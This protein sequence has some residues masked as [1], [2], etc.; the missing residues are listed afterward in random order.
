MASAAPKGGLGGWRGGCGRPIHFPRNTSLP[1]FARPPLLGYRSFDRIYSA[2]PTPH[3]LRAVCSLTSPDGDVLSAPVTT[4][5]HVSPFPLTMGCGPNLLLCDVVRFPSSSF[6][7]AENVP[8]FTGPSFCRS[9][10]IVPSPLR[11][12]AIQSPHALYRFL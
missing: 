3:V 10:I 5:P 9:K 6:L 8:S 12:A 7:L 1:P 2:F 4:P 11:V